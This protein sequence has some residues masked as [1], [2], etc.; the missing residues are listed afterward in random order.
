[1]H[2]RGQD[3]AHHARRSSQ[4]RFEH[5][6]Y[7]HGEHYAVRRRPSSVSQSHG[8]FAGTVIRELQSA[9][10]R[11]VQNQLSATMWAVLALAAVYACMGLM[12]VIVQTWQVTHRRSV[13]ATI[14]SSSYIHL[15]GYRLSNSGSYLPLVR[16]TYL[17]DG[18]TYVGTNAYPGDL[19]HVSYRNAEDMV[20]RFPAGRHVAAFYV[21]SRP[22]ESFLV[23]APVF[24]DY[25]RLIGA[26]LVIGLIFFYHVRFDQRTRRRYRWNGGQLVIALLCTI[27]TIG[28]Y[29]QYF[30][31][32]GIWSDDAVL[33]FVITVGL[34]AGML[35]MSANLGRHRPGS[36]HAHPSM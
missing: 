27:L 1:V 12:Q 26:L 34:D 33:V 2:P 5:R 29:A 15:H 20:A 18:T 6:C 31:I 23:D 10:M 28:A 14:L 16:F 17:V 13:P 3:D 7:A 30:A 9:W 35:I 21:P 25:V 4:R 24:N 8:Y 22:A 11:P 32:G 36:H 19:Q